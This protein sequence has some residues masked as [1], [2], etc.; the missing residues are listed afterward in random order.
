M[1]SLGE[2]MALIDVINFAEN[3]Q[4]L[5]IYG[6]GNYGSDLLEFL[7]RYGLNA[8]MFIVSDSQVFSS[9]DEHMGIPVFGLSAA[10]RMG[11]I[12][13]VAA[14]SELYRNDI[15]Q[16]L[17]D[18]Q[19]DAYYISDEEAREI[20]RI[21]Q[22][23]DTN[24]LLERTRPFSRYFG[25][26]RGTPVDRY[27]MNSFLE[28]VAG[29]TDSRAKTV[30]EVG[31]DS[32]SRYFFPD[33]KRIDILDFRKGMDL[34]V[35]G[36]IAEEEYDIFLCMQTYNFIYHVAEAVKGSFRLLKPGGRLIATVA[37]NISQVSSYDMS[38]YGDYWRFTYLSIRKLI[39][40]VF[41][42][43]VSVFPYGN[44]M[45]A[46]AFLQG[47][48]VEDLKDVSLLD[49]NDPDYSILIGLVADKP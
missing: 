34:T 30:L 26:D 47:I 22:P 27:Y 31:E 28:M 49:I 13:V 16:Q 11:L 36:S 7:N 6:A 44:V 24:R 23:L 14:V 8:E 12:N 29:A 40:E 4:P 9:G 2:K 41:P 10:L 39:E 1:H 32:Y 33:A 43:G 17:L 37:G 48:A 42:Q 3:R 15:R 25:Y 21:V 18:R 46:T 19:I 45:A 20:K 38:H 5:A 35:K